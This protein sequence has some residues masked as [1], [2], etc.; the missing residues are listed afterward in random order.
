MRWLPKIP[1]WML[2][3]LSSSLWGVF[4]SSYECHTW[5]KKWGK[6]GLYTKV[7]RPHLSNPE[8]H[9]DLGTM[10]QAELKTFNS[11]K[12][13]LP[14]WKAIFQLKERRLCKVQEKRS[15]DSL[16]INQLL[17]NNM[18]MSQVNTNQAH[19]DWISLEILLGSKLKGWR[20][21]GVRILRKLQPTFLQTP[22]TWKILLRYG[23]ARPHSC[24]PES[25]SRPAD[26]GFWRWA[27]I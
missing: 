22:N 11:E 23:L 4:P 6:K 3:K 25:M 27:H 26:L 18:S 20:E 8:F 21:G 7:L 15:E 13:Y 9:A 19:M 2:W 12:C 17:E 5:K 14:K 10:F 16:Y 1:A 24:W